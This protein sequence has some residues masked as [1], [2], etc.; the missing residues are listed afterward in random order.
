[1]RKRLS[2]RVALVT[3][4]G[5]GIGR[6]T[7]VALA[8]RG[9]FVAVA[10]IDLA[11]ARETAALIGPAAAALR[12]D[13]VDQPAFDAAVAATI[14]RHGRLDVLVNNAG[15]MPIG[16]F[17]DESPEVTRRVLAVNVEGVCN[18]MRAALGHMTERGEGQIVNLASVVG[19]H[20]SPLAV[21]YAG[22]K[23][24]VVGIT[25]TL[26]RELRGSGV[27]L[28]L[29]CPTWTSTALT[30]GT[31]PAAGLPR[32]TP[33]QVAERVLH[34]IR[35][36][37]RVVFAPPSAGASL[38]LTRMLPLAVEEALALVTRADDALRPPA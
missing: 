5:Q 27:T 25:N 3:G 36:R 19:F 12:L 22:S 15:I 26:R 11:K 2:G 32:A 17:A 31:S 4:A 1:M 21:T 13:V 16:P 10:D 34:A 14:E 29:V 24:A 37:R 8:R 6:A 7:A 30:A 28:T 33:E 23:H 20:G 9:M 35:R 38:R 18:G